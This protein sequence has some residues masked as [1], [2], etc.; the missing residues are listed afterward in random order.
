VL[1]LMDRVESPT[2]CR[3]KQGLHFVMRPDNS[4]QL[5]HTTPQALD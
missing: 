3:D 1:L 4:A 2:F 5:L